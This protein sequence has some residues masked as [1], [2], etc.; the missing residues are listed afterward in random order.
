M[1]EAFQDKLRTL[2]AQVEQKLGRCLLRFQAYEAA[3]KDLLGQQKFTA[4]LSRMDG[5]APYPSDVSRKTLGSLVKQLLADF[6]ILENKVDSFGTL[7]QNEP[8]GASVSFQFQISMADNDWTQLDANLRD[9]VNLRNDL[10]HHFLERHDLKNSEGCHAAREALDDAYDR[11]G[12]HIKMLGEW[13]EDMSQTTSI[14]AK[15]I[16]SDSIMKFL[17]NDEIPWSD[18]EVIGVF[19]EVAASV[20][21]AGWTPISE[22]LE[23][24][25]IRCPDELP[26]NYGC[27][28]WN[29]VLHESRLFTLRYIERG[30]TRALFYKEKAKI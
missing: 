17:V 28:S 16:G 18:L 5:D 8:T 29:Q 27:V 23:L 1:T 2:Q 24:I 30:E 12:G 26:T 7:D 10:V 13:L 22:A 14:A 3:V 21:F 11:I 9:F 25:L 4:L 6:L 15:Y 19:R 20:S